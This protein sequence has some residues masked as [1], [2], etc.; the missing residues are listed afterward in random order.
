MK[1]SP[2]LEMIRCVRTAL[3][4]SS[5]GLGVAASLVAALAQKRDRRV[6]G[7]VRSVLLGVP[8]ERAFSKLMSSQETG[9]ELLSFLVTQAK[10]DSALAARD[11]AQLSSLFERWAILRE[12]REME[13]R[14]MG[15][16][17]AVVSV[18][19]GV[20]VGMISCLAPLLSS[21]QSAFSAA[22]DAPSFSPY[23]GVVLL[24]PAAISLGFY[25]SPRRPYLDCALSATSFFLVVYFLSPLTSFTFPR[26]GG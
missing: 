21:F 5:W 9:G 8:I 1:Q 24:L 7:A 10:M 26:V 16:R 12:R 11:A 13:E 23:E 3:R 20:V 17:G 15:F 14:V 2:Q 19:A 22:A 25:L 6:R 4:R 18:V